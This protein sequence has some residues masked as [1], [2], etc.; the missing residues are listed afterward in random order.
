M[1][2]NSCIKQLTI[3]QFFNFE[4][5]NTCQTLGFPLWCVWVFGLVYFCF[6]CWWCLFRSSS[7]IYGW[8]CEWVCGA[9]VWVWPRRRGGVGFRGRCSPWCPPACANKSTWTP[10]MS[11]P[12]RRP[13]LPALQ[14]I[15]SPR[16]RYWRT[17]F[18]GHYASYSRRTI[19]APGSWR[20]DSAVCVS[21]GY[22]VC[23]GT[24]CCLKAPIHWARCWSSC[25]SWTCWRRWIPTTW[26]CWSG[27][28]ISV[29]TSCWWSP[30]WW[31]LTSTCWS[32]GRFRL[33]TTSWGWGSWSKS[34]CSNSWSTAAPEC[35]G[36]A[37]VRCC[38][39][40]SHSDC[41]TGNFRCLQSA[42]WWCCIFPR[43][44]SPG[45]CWTTDSMFSSWP[46]CWEWID[47]PWVFRL[48]RPCNC[49]P[50]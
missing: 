31:T 50:D 2:S 27:P 33:P 41:W 42:H 11:L 43:A 10:W 20:G 25:W 1:Y 44:A 45:S 18:L 15:Q 46:V 7:W 8:R 40:P 32:A 28:G 47:C 48:T 19:G 36:C 24:R 22:L 3:F 6:S 26:R 14:A 23:W 30:Q 34:G 37:S 39:D 49:L 4:Y 17:L 13:F 12:S 16:Y 21:F 35:R 9:G 29:W 38:S 5:S